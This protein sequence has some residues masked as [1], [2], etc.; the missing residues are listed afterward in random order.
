MKTKRNVQALV[1][2]RAGKDAVIILNKID[3][4]LKRGIARKKIESALAK[5]LIA[6]VK[7]HKSYLD[8]PAGVRIS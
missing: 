3:K 4:M 1:R 8:R 5:E 6:H 7:K 2:K